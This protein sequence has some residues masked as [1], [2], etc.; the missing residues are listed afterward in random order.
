M[1]DFFGQFGS[2]FLP[3]R[4]VELKD[5]S[6]DVRERLRYLCEET[7]EI[8]RTLKEL[9]SMSVA[10]SYVLDDALVSALAEDTKALEE[11][12]QKMRQVEGSEKEL[13]DRIEASVKDIQS[14]AENLLKRL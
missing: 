10:D 7:E 6:K 12:L 9:S 11:C 4:D 13:N 3:D 14:S 8:V 1:D 2:I 5:R